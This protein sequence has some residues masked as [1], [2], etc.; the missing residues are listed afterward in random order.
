MFNVNNTNTKK[1]VKYVKVNN[2]NTR[3]TTSFDEIL[4]KRRI[5]FEKYLKIFQIYVQYLRIANFY[6]NN[7]DPS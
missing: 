4:E 5:K 1:G 7:F 2:K 3:T 6:H